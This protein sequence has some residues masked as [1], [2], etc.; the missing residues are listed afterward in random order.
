[1]AARSRFRDDLDHVHIN[2]HVREID[3]FNPPFFRQ[4]F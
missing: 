3:G 2:F 1:M 4:S